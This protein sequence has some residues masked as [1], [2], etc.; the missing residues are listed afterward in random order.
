VAALELGL[1][2][3]QALRPGLQP[4]V[5]DCGCA[6][7]LPHPHDPILEVGIAVV[8]YRLALAAAAA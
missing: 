6:S 5:V 2:V 4:A 3:S 8:A 1:A 7:A